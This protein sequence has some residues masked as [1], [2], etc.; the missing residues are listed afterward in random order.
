MLVEE[1]VSGRNTN[2][3]APAALQ[4]T[5]HCPKSLSFA[6]LAAGVPPNKYQHAQATVA[7]SNAQQIKLVGPSNIADIGPSP[8]QLPHYFTALTNIPFNPMSSVISS[9]MPS[10][11][12]QVPGNVDTSQLP[13][14]L[15]VISNCTE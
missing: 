4:S 15:M 12:Q 8:T 6:D 14:H 2:S 9:T 13:H 5:Q 7:A 3:E 10:N 1:S 11:I